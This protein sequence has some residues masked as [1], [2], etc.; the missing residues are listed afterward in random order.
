MAGIL[1]YLNKRLSEPST[2]RGGILLLSAFGITLMPEQIE[3]IIAVGLFLAG[4]IGALMPDKTIDDDE[5]IPYSETGVETHKSDPT[6]C[7]HCN[8]NI[9]INSNLTE[10]KTCHDTKTYP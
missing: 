8:T 1:G 6:P 9:T 7:K 10:I 5:P 3:A 2:W 4:I